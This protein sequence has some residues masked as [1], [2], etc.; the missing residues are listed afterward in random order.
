MC[1]EKRSGHMLISQKRS[2]KT[3]SQSLRSPR[4]TFILSIILFIITVFLLAFAIHFITANNTLGSDFAT[5]WIGSK[6]AVYEGKSPYSAEVI[7]DSQLFIYHRLADPN[8]DQVA[9]AYPLQAVFVIA[10][11]SWL[12]IAWAQ[13]FWM[14]LTIITL[15]TA[16]YI[17]MPWAKGYIRFTFFFFYPVIFGII[18]GNFAILFTSF[19]LLFLYLI[20][21]RKSPSKAIQITCAILL[22]IIIIKPQFAWGFFLLGFLVSLKNRYWTF[23][24]TLFISTISQFI[25]TFIWRP[26]WPAEWIQILKLYAVYN[27][28]KPTIFI[29]LER[30]LPNNLVY[31]AA[32]LIIL[33]GITALLW[34]IF[35]WWKGNVSPALLPAWIG[36]LTYLIHPHGLSY[37]QLTFFIPFLLWACLQPMTHRLIAGWI[38]SIIF[39][40]VVYFITAFNIIPV[41]VNEYPFLFYILWLA[42]FAAKE[43]RISHQKS[44]TPALVN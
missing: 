18:L 16:L 41:A 37:E 36:F 10:P 31:P 5:F 20:Y 40:W 1:P 34:I 6:S 44:G 28:V 17:F 43:W 42:W 33:F 35:S 19:I 7:R 32:G 25:L 13:A 8:E 15:L 27:K 14:S 9:F 23:L 38:I 30:M 11:F 3:L 12:D 21:I 2:M 29:H 22:S 39:S 24:I 4:Y 26:G